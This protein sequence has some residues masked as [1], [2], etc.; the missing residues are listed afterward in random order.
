MVAE[1]LELALAL[2]RDEL[3]GQ[4]IEADALLKAQAQAARRAG[5]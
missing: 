5:A 2:P 1:A 3:H 4:V